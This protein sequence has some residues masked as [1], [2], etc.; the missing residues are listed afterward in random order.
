M[1]NSFKEETAI[2]ISHC[3]LKFTPVLPNRFSQLHENTDY[4]GSYY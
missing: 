1:L 2:A 4:W 3:M